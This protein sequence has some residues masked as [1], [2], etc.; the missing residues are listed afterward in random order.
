MENLMVI[1]LEVKELDYIIQVL[2]D[3]PWRETQ[4]LIAKLVAQANTQPPSERV[5]M[6]E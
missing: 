2:A 5:E 3:R 6:A 4:A 1:T